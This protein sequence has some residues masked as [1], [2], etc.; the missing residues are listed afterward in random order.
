MTKQVK[1][2]LSDLI[3]LNDFLHEEGIEREVT[4]RAAERVARS[5]TAYG[6]AVVDLLNPTDDMLRAFY[7]AQCPPGDTPLGGTTRWAT[8]EEARPNRAPEI[9]KCLAAMIQV[10]IDEGSE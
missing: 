2:S 4:A 6:R 8:W 7:E 3:S 5:S 9:K 10:A 1:R